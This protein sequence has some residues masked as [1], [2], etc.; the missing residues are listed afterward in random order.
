MFIVHVF[1]HVK[2]EYIEDFKVATL[3]NVRNSIREPGIARFDFLEEPD[4]AH[5]VLLEVYRTPEDAAKHKE[6]A[7]YL[8][9]RDTVEH[10]MAEPRSSIKLSNIAPDNAG[11]E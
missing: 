6:T 3:A 4:A 9:W 1:I 5:F 10:M 11:W 7:H 8:V 2:P